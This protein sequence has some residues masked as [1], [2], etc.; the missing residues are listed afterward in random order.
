MFT[1]EISLTCAIIVF[2]L[3]LCFAHIRACSQYRGI[4]L[5]STLGKLFSRILN[6]RLTDWAGEYHIYVEALAGFR[7]NMGTI[8]NIFVL[9]GVINHMLNENKKLYVALFDYIKDFNYVVRENIWYKL[10]NYGV[11]GKIIDV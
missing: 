7:K 10:L 1:L 11:R 9:H 5:L 4:T 3:S 6:N 8:D 2:D